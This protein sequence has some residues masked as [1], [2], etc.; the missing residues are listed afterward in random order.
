M[1]D[2]IERYENTL[3]AAILEIE[4]IYELVHQSQSIEGELQF[5]QL[6]QVRGH[7]FKLKND[8]R[9]SLILS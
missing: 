8:L 3:D 5:R 2:D 1:T 4:N 7:L 9:R 6:D